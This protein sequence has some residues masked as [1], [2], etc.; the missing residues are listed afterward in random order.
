MKKFIVLAVLMVYGFAAFGVSL[1]YFYCCGKLKEVSIQLN[2]PVDHKCPMKGG[3]D[4]CKNKKVE[5][6]ISADQNFSQQIS[7]EP[8][9]FSLLVSDV[10]SIDF[11]KPV[12]ENQYITSYLNIPPPLSDSDFP[13]LYHSFLI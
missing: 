11:Q 13:V 12:F 6:K 8:L 10:Y 1:N 4:C 5:A 7:F 2:T 3:I 9:D